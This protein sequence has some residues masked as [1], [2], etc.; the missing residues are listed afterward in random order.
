MHIK[1][2]SWCLEH[3]VTSMGAGFVGV[4]NTTIQNF[5]PELCRSNM[6]N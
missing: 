3:S 2:I 6:L 4:S 5:I 1:V